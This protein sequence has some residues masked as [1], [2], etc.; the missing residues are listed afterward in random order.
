MAYTQSIS[1][2]SPFE[3]LE[4]AETF[5][6]YQ[7]ASPTKP[8]YFLLCHAIRLVLKA[9]IASR[10]P[11]ARDRCNETFGNDLTALLDEAISLG[12]KISASTESEIEKL[13]TAHVKYFARYPNETANRVLVI[14]HL[15]G[16]HVEELF[17]AVRLKIVTQ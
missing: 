12:L 15:G 6:T 13:S 2:C 9:Y 14:E 5:W 3:L 4:R 7:K 10:R 8:R 16:Q 17:K 1:L 11:A